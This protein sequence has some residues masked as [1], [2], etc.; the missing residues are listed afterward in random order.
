MTAQLNLTYYIVLFLAV[1]R[2][3]R[4]RGLSKSSISSTV[5]IIC[6]LTGIVV[7]Y[8]PPSSIQ[9]DFY[10]QFELILIGGELILCLPLAYLYFRKTEKPKE[11][12]ISEHD[13]PAIQY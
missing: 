10:F 3:K 2:I 1:A 12:L 9:P 5:A 4:Q 8:L 11:D 13:E 6:C 7:G